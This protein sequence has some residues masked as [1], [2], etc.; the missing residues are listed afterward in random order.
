MRLLLS[1][2]LVFSIEFSQVDLSYYLP[3]DISYDQKISKPADIL[4]FQIG[5]WHLRADQVQDYLTVLAKESNR[6]QMM[7]MGESYEQRPTTL[8]IVS[9]P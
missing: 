2:L 6:M 9:S 8:L 7:P 5:D 3:A 4:G 1:V